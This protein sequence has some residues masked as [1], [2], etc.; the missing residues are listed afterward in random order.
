MSIKGLTDKPRENPPRLGQLRKGAKKTD[1][2]KPGAD[3]TYFRFESID[4]KIKTRFKD[5]YG[6]EPRV[7]NVSL[8][9][10]SVEENFPTWREE[11]G[12]G[13]MKH[14]CDGETMVL[15]QD[16][17]G[18]FSTE[19]K[20]CPYADLPKGS[21]ERKCKP[22]G[23]LY[24]MIPEL[25]YHWA[26][27]QVITGSIWD[28][29]ELTNN[30]VAVEMM[31]Q[32]ASV[33]TG[34][35]I[36]MRGI[37]CLLKRE[38]RMISTPS[39]SDGQR[40]RREKWLLHLEISPTFVEKLVRSMQRYSLPVADLPQ[41]EAPEDLELD[42]EPYEN[43]DNTIDGEFTETQPPEIPTNGGDEETERARDN[44]YAYILSQ[45]PYYNHENHIKNTLKKL[46]FT[47]Y[48]PENEEKM[49][50]AL[51]EYANKEANKELVEEELPF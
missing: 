9:F 34:R 12:A 7:I 27:V 47:G 35:P 33:I 46:G 36:D 51:Q 22:S 13:G 40:V 45:I 1:P 43:G 6:D 14:R 3:L 38:P 29:L 8:L 30:L 11:H 25:G 21:P 4:P 19:P 41:L 28:C 49:L 39:G 48:K 24:V 17:T 18:Q 5:V 42:Y 37:P 31:A 20:P 44:F 23:E 16:E 10:T 50:L 2:K 15:W 32:R 26:Y